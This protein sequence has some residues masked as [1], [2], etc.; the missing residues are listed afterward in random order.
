M[1]Q[2]LN[3]AAIL[4]PL[5]IIANEKGDVLHALKKQEETFKGFGEAY[6]STAAPGVFKGW[7]KHTEMVLNLIVP[8]GTIRFYIVDGTDET[9]STVVTLSKEN[10]NRLTVYPGT[11]LGFEGLD[12]GLNMLLNIASVPHNPAEALQ[13]EKEYFAGLFAELSAV[14]K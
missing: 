14:E 10:Y 12:K 13:K 5:K 7:K 9:K 3:G 2:L 11:W 6:F 8:V 4:T 1:V